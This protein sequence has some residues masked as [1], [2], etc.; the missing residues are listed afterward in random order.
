MLTSG[1]LILV[2]LLGL[3]FPLD[4][5][6]QLQYDDF[7]FIIIYFVMFSCYALEACTS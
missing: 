5:L 6:V 1:S 4:Q 7:H 2:F 3:I